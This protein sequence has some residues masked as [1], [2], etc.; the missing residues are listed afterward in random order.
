MKPKS[1]PLVKVMCRAPHYQICSIETNRP[2]LPLVDFAELKLACT[3]TVMDAHTAQLVIV[4]IENPFAGPLSKP[5]SGFGLLSVTAIDYLIIC[6]RQ[7][8]SFRSQGYRHDFTRPAKLH[9]SILEARP[10]K[11]FKLVNLGDLLDLKEF[12][13]T[14]GVQF[15]A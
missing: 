8:G 7:N 9:G 14:K 12:S 13:C 3:M 11:L 10:H 4:S 5:R 15:T 2:D 6:E 1:V